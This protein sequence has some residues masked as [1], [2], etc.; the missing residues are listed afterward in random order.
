MSLFVH[1]TQRCE[2]EAASA[3][4]QDDFEKLKNKVERAQDLQGFDH[5]PAPYRVKK[6]FPRYNARVIASM[7]AVG[8]H[9][10]ACFLTILTKADSAYDQFQHNAVE[11]GRQ[12]FSE[13]T[14]ESDLE[15]VVSERTAMHKRY[16]IIVFFWWIPTTPRTVEKLVGDAVAKYL[17]AGCDAGGVLCA[18]DLNDC[19][20]VRWI[21][22][23]PGE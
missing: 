12:H 10:V 16:R 6:K 20:I 9:D 4:W 5:F 7:H 2:E 19:L 17:L 14:T 23:L 21:V 13:L 3:G 11:F 22:P 15:R 8:D 18:G 1:V